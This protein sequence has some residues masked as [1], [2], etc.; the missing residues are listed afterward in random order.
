MNIGAMKRQKEESRPG[1]AY[2][3]RWC[4]EAVVDNK[5]NIYRLQAL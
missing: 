1:Q 4:G 5:T 3:W 2:G